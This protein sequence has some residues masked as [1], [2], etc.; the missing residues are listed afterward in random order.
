MGGGSA[1]FPQALLLNFGQG[2]SHLRV[3][4]SLDHFCGDLSIPFLLGKIFGSA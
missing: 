3:S 4:S 1:Q 2:K